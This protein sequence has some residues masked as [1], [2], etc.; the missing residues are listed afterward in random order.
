MSLQGKI[1]FYDIIGTLTLYASVDHCYF[2]VPSN[3]NMSQEGKVFK[4][5]YYRNLITSSTCISVILSGYFQSEHVAAG[6]KFKQRY[7]RNINTLS[8]CRPVLLSFNVQFEHVAPGES[9]QTT[10]LSEH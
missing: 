9:V 7:Y 4:Q 5:R 2:Q 10:I 1:S 8:L 3:L 6:K